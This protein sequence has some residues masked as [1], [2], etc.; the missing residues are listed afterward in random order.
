MSHAPSPA[1][2]TAEPAPL[3]VAGPT[4]GGKSALALALA[5]AEGG[6]L[7]NADSQQVYGGWRILTAR[8]A[9]A[10]EARAPHRLYG[11]VGLGT[12]YSVGAWLREAAAAIEAARAEGRVPIVVGGTGLYFKALTT[13]IAPIPAVDPAVRAEGEA[14]LERLGLARFAR[15]LAEADPATAATL[16]LRNPMRV[17]RAWE[18]L[19]AT[20]EGL[21]VWR[22]RTG[23]PVVDPAHAR[24]IALL[25]PRARLFERIEARL[26]AMIG[27]GVLD[28]VAAVMDLGLPP[29]APGLKPVGAGELM[30]HLA[31][32]LSLDDALRAAKTQTRRYAKR[33]LTWIR[34]QM[35]DWPALSEPDPA[36]R[37]AEARALLSGRGGDPGPS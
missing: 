7:V 16:D 4:A 6:V 30:A 34:N 29:E 14:R 22:A 18:V 3:L 12:P 32:R 35:A 20:G 25:P 26:D 17:L 19:E 37:L 28:E 24:R 33:Q 10:E 15:A 8:P 1:R 11:H 36:A 9:P 21:A 5:E 13:G 2:D 27:E 31:G 23:P